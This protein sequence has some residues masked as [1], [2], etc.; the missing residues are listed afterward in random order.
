M[1]RPHR[2]LWFP[3]SALLSFFC[4]ACWGQ[5][6][7][8]PKA[9]RQIPP[10]PEIVRWERFGHILEGHEQVGTFLYSADLTLDPHGDPVA[11]APRR[12]RVLVELQAGEAS[13][14]RVLLAFFQQ[15]AP[16]DEG[17]RESGS[18]AVFADPQ[19]NQWFAFRRRAQAGT[20]PK[21]R[22]PEVF[23]LYET[24][25]W[26]SSWISAGAPAEERRQASFL[27]DQVPDLWQS[28]QAVLHLLPEENKAFPDYFAITLRRLA[29]VFGWPESP[30]RPSLAYKVLDKRVARGESRANSL[31]PEFERRFGPWSHW[32][33]LPPKLKW[34]F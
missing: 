14:P 21:G 30:S 23:V 29:R 7:P 34:L 5:E 8:E 28:L 31:A 22:F 26:R 2:R 13:K 17:T 15:M 33:K 25:S 19:S 12:A 27:A 9:V 3:C 10:Q 20:D 32:D 24:S 18:V 4:G 11:E 16:A 6:E 1:L